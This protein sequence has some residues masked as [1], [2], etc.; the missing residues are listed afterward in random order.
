M[1]MVWQSNAWKDTIILSFLNVSPANY[2]ILA[3]NMTLENKI[4]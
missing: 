1:I 2:V 3:Y 4:N